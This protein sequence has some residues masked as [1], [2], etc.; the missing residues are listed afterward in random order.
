MTCRMTYIINNRRIT[1]KW[2]GLTHEVVLSLKTDETNDDIGIGVEILLR[3]VY[4][5]WFIC[6][7]IF[8]FT[9]RDFFWRTGVGGWWWLVWKAFLRHTRSTTRVKGLVPSD[10]HSK[11][12]NVSG[13]LLYPTGTVEGHHVY[14]WGKF[15]LHPTPNQSNL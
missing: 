1:D 9:L 10:V 14:N 2:E 13:P 6:K 3:I 5:V 4:H 8:L 7:F 11:V 15:P 12:L